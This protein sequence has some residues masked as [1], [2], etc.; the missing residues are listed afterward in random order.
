MR[1]ISRD[2]YDLSNRYA[3]CE[4]DPITN[5]DPNGHMSTNFILGGVGIL[6]SLILVPFSG[7]SAFALVGVLLGGTS[8]L[9]QAEAD[10]TGNENLQWLSMGLAIA[11]MAFDLAGG[12][13]V[14]KGVTRKAETITNGL[15]PGRLRLG[16][17]EAPVRRLSSNS[18]IEELK[19]TAES[20]LERKKVGLP[21]VKSLENEFC[22]GGIR[23]EYKDI[24]TKPN[25]FNTAGTTE[26]RPLDLQAV[27]VPESRKAFVMKYGTEEEIQKVKGIT[28]EEMWQ[29]NR[30]AVIGPLVQQWGNEERVS[31]PTKLL[32]IKTIYIA[33]RPNQTLQGFLEQLRAAGRNI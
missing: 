11:S 2:T 22:L 8:L 12:I 21:D 6:A 10:K 19:T 28:Q 23:P 4:G 31:L 7:G 18:K 1:F 29:E 24:V 15:K 3:Y 33:Y 25:P 13:A 27:G 17:G 5:I 16:A 26:S 30:E 9:I 14:V 20:V 32:R